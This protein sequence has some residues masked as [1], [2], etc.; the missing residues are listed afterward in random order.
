M[1]CEEEV[2][3]AA[4]W[5]RLG[6]L[7]YRKRSPSLDAS[8]YSGEAREGHASGL[9]QGFL[10]CPSLPHRLYFPWKR[11]LSSF[12]RWDLSGTPS[13]TSQPVAGLRAQHNVKQKAAEL[14]PREVIKSCLWRTCKCRWNSILK[15][16]LLLLL[17]EDFMGLVCAN[18]DNQGEQ[19]G[20]LVKSGGL[21]CSISNSYESTDSFK[22]R[23]SKRS[24][25]GCLQHIM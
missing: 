16:L 14:H 4:L 15:S 17:S 2:V 12:S 13:N 23:F 18:V 11:D 22:K 19:P 8:H 1:S 9:C 3:R 6:V 21:E 7:I 20:V 10:L 5:I 25:R 24:E